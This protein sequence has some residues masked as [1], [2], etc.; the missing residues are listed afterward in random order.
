MKNNT[1]TFTLRHSVDLSIL[2]RFVKPTRKSFLITHQTLQRLGIKANASARAYNNQRTS[3]TG[4]ISY[5]YSHALKGIRINAPLRDAYR[6]SGDTVQTHNSTH[7]VESSAPNANQHANSTKPNGPYPSNTPSPAT[8]SNPASPP[9]CVDASSLPHN[10]ASKGYSKP[11]YTHGIAAF[12]ARGKPTTPRSFTDHAHADKFVFLA[13]GVEPDNKDRP[14]AKA[15]RQNCKRRYQIS[16]NGHLQYKRNGNRPTSVPAQL[17]NAISEWRTIPFADE[18]WDIVAN[19]HAKNHKCTNTLER[20]VSL[21]YAVPNLRDIAL[22]VRK[23]CTEC[24]KFAPPHKV[25]PTWILTKRKGQIVMFDLSKLSITLEDGTVLQML[26]VIDHFTKYKMGKIVLSKDHGPIC[27]YMYQL[28]RKEGTP[29]RWHADNG[30]EFKN[31]WMDK[32]RQR[33]SVN[34]SDDVLLPYSHSLPRNPQ[35]QGL[36]ERANRTVKSKLVKSYHDWKKAHPGVPVTL[37]VM[38]ELYQGVLDEENI[39][40][41]KL[42]QCTPHLLQRGKPPLTSSAHTFCPILL[43]N[44]FE[45]CAQAQVKRAFKNKADYVDRDIFEAYKPGRVVRVASTS[46]MLNKKEAP[47]GMRWPWLA[48]I[49]RRT[50]HTDH[51]YHLKWI[52]PGPTTYDKPGN[53]AKRAFHATQLKPGTD[54]EQLEFGYEDDEEESQSDTDASGKSL[55]DHDEAGNSDD[56]TNEE[57]ASERS[58]DDENESPADTASHNEQDSTDDSDVDYEVEAV[59]CTRR[60]NGVQEFYVKWKGYTQPTWETGKNMDNCKDVLEKFTSSQ[61]TP[62]EVC[63]QC[64]A[65]PKNNEYELKRCDQCDLYVCLS[66]VNEDCCWREKDW[67]GETTC[68]ACLEQDNR[69]KDEE[70]DGD[71]PNDMQD[72]VMDIPLAP[73]PTPLPPTDEDVPISARRRKKQKNLHRRCKKKVVTLQA[74][75]YVG[76]W[77]PM[78]QMR[79]H[80]TYVKGRICEVQ[81]DCTG[82]TMYVVDNTDCV[83]FAY[84]GM[85]VQVDIY[86]DN[87]KIIG[88][89]DTLNEENLKESII[90]GGKGRITRR[91]QRAYVRRS[92]EAKANLRTPAGSTGLHVLVESDD[93]EPSED[94]QSDVTSEDERFKS[95][96]YVRDICCIESL[97]HMF[98]SH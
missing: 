13:S 49:E 90:H 62:A 19:E 6:V 14:S 43:N 36:V 37:E 45:R 79:L 26:L 12:K 80:Q 77:L 27:D 18:E 44:L 89:I 93:P 92:N 11:S 52:H 70:S 48:T 31:K 22:E 40:E 38:E 87:G 21:H 1:T 69:D 3:K 58:N 56:A 98:T 71:S 85:M 30:S 57:C 39:T 32:V 83:H 88:S 5:S 66:H 54:A 82:S 15:W 67:Y 10:T 16:D 51:C 4:A 63:Q 25:G 64:R 68:G 55:S 47:F 42:Y 95:T 53:I 73:A 60:R 33:L 94:T 96:R 97:H 24:E 65:A 29:E 7:P 50:K 91:M 17:R 59:L 28:M 76:A 20:T 75:D 84:D 41:I 78:A 23:R 2:L 46:Q 35:C 8:T 81:V 74:G 72:E 34:D 9:P 61:D 86:D